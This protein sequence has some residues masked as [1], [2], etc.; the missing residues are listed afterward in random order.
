MNAPGIRWFLVVTVAAVAACMVT[1]GSDAGNVLYAALYL[2]LCGMSWWAARRQSHG[3]RLPWVLIA[4][5][6]TLWFTGD[7]IEL[8]QSYVGTVP[9]V[10][11]ADAFWLSGYPLL[12]AA[13]AL[14]ARRRA[15]GRM[16]PAVLDSLTL[17]VAAGAASWQFLVEPVLSAGYGVADSVIPALYPVGD[18]VLLAGTLLIALSPGTRTAPTRLLLAAVGLYLGV[19]LGY[20]LLPYVLDYSLVS[21]IGPLIALGNALIVAAA[22][23]PARGELMHPG[24]RATVLHP[25]RVLFLGLALMTAPMLTMLQSGFDQN[26]IILIIATTACAAFVLTRFTTAVREQE[27]TQAELAFQARHDPLTGLSNRAVLADRLGR[28]LPAADAPVSVLYLDLDG[29]KQ[30]N[31]EHG[32]EAG[33]AV[34][35]VVSRRLSAAV[36]E[37]D[38]VTRLGGDEFV[39]L[40]PAAPPAEAIRLAER[41]LHDV[42]QPVIWNGLTLHVGASI[43]IAAETDGAEISATDVLRSADIAMYQAKRQGRG[44]FVVAGS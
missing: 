31:D 20:N 22:L 41:V 7:A 9:S 23:H 14:M 32:H 29:F 25:A 30:I 39:M 19:D 21:R 16:R 10:G 2:S 27:R 17:T 11:V 33:D 35:R 42:A 3:A 26:Q 8:V 13:L 5:A 28:L 15:P 18:V 37:T 34:L 44:R 24:P 40:C 1:Y 38:L 43:G 6:I 36:R 12:A 4:T